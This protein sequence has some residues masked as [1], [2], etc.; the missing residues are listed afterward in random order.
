MNRDSLRLTGVKRNP[1]N[2]YLD[3]LKVAEMK[4]LK[5]LRAANLSLEIVIGDFIIYWL[6][7]IRLIFILVKVLILGRTNHH[8]IRSELRDILI[9]KLWF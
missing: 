9:K 5:E 7:N 8:N 3:V 2:E 1:L 6:G 4:N